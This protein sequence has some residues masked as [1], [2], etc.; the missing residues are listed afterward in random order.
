MVSPS[1]SQDKHR[2][3]GSGTVL[4]S[5]VFSPSLLLSALSI[6]NQRCH[7]VSILLDKPSVIWG[8]TKKGNHF[9][10]CGRY[11]P[12]LDLLHVLVYHL[13]SVLADKVSQVG[14]CILQNPTLSQTE[15]VLSGPSPNKSVLWCCWSRWEC[16]Q[17]RWCQSS[18]AICLMLVVPIC[19]THSGCWWGQRPC[20]CGN[21]F[22]SE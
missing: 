5:L 2:L 10:A 7:C 17:D 1:Y 4:L 8:E 11:R 15:H 20:I 6:V 16:H 14:H 13:Y 22:Q 21:R 18:E 12:V 19:S 3:V 9:F